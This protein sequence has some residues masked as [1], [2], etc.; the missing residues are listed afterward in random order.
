MCVF[1]LSLQLE[2]DKAKTDNV[3]GPQPTSSHILRPS[4]ANSY[5]LRAMLSLL[6][7]NRTKGSTCYICRRQQRHGKEDG[8][9]VVC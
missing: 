4:T 9:C 7:A 8:D 1:G 6:Q 3:K 5:P 2:K